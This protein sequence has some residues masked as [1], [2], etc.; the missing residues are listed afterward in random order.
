MFKNNQD[1]VK[2]KVISAE[3][4]SGNSKFG[5][6]LH[7]G[8]IT[9]IGEMPSSHQLIFTNIY[10]NA[11]FS[12]HPQCHF[13]FPSSLRSDAKNIYMFSP[14]IPTWLCKK[15]FLHFKYFFSSSRCKWSILASVAIHDA[16][17]SSPFLFG[18]VNR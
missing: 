5:Q 3:T 6:F 15:K 16:S 18:F 2:E 4:S 11:H 17:I 9:G 13:V 8:E 12:L 7:W 14:F 10:L 1:H